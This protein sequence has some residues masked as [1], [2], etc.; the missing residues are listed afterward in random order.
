[1]KIVRELRLSGGKKYNKYRNAKNEMKKERWRL[2]CE[3]RCRNY[4]NRRIFNRCF[5]CNILHEVEMMMEEELH[6]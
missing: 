6:Q 4:G 1:M 2:V 5:R 3:G